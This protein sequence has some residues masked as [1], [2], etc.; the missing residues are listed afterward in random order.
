MARVAVVHHGFVPTFRAP[1]FERLAVRSDIEYVVFHGEPPPGEGFRAAP[2][3]YRFPHRRVSNRCVRVAGRSI[4][5]Q[6][7]ARPI[8]RGGFDAAVLGA[9]LK[10][11]ANLPVA[12]T[13]M[14]RGRPVI[15][16]GQGVD[17]ADDLGGAAIR[18]LVAGLKPRIARRATGYLAYTDRGRARL[19]AEGLDAERITVVRNTLDVDAQ[20]AL[21]DEL[22]GADE[23]ALRRDLGLRPDSAVLLYLGRVYR[24]K[25]VDELVALARALGAD[26]ALPPVETVV[27]GDGPD[28]ERVRDLAAGV[29]G[30][31]FEGEVYDPGRVARWLRVATAVVIPGKVGLA[32]NHALAHGVPVL[33]RESDLHA[34]EVEYLEHR[35]NGLI[36]PGGHPE[37][38]AAVA[39]VVADTALRRSLAEGALASREALGLDAMVAAFDGGVRRALAAARPRRRPRGATARSTCSVHR[40]CEW[41][42][43]PPAWRSSSPST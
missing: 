10:F 11:P 35:R 22:A 27:V 20:R 39:E 38:T 34:P 19:E 5:W 9:E 15:I 18:S 41:S 8:L 42:W 40:P 23:L 36:V 24:E 43:S 16:W 37:F 14:A 29:D 4:V 1:F 6:P 33:T 30:V 25:R 7:I 2:E 13:L 32:V 31:R 28:L 3:P 21:H 12:G 26:V 17:K